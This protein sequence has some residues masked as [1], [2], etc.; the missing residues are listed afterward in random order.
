MK[1]LLPTI[2][3]THAI[4]VATVTVVVVELIPVL[5]ETGDADIVVVEL[6]FIVIEVVVLV[7]A[8]VDVVAVVAVVTVVVVDD[9]VV[10]LQTS[11]ETMTLNVTQYSSDCT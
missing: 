7:V 3:S 11:A 8:V 2:C 1:L 6:V 5:V 10:V 9:V 4:M